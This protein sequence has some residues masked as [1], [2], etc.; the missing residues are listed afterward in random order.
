MDEH[1]ALDA[2]VGHTVQAMDLAEPSGTAL[3]GS[4][5]DE[6]VQEQGV[7]RVEVIAGALA[8]ARA[9]I[10]FLSR[11]S[12]R[13][14]LALWQGP[15]LDGGYFHRIPLLT[16]W[17]SDIIVHLPMGNA[18]WRLN[19]ASAFLGAG[20]TAVIAVATTRAAKSIV[21]PTE[22]CATGIAAGAV[23]A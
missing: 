2:E 21:G 4:L 20:A 18:A 17:L 15:L 9:I 22:A 13:V 5:P 19:M 14:A 6:G 1:G 8:G 12:P 11:V 16:A 10:W 7:W 3:S 23:F